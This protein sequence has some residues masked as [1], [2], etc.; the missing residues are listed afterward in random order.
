MRAWFRKARDAARPEH[1]PELEH[2]LGGVRH[3]MKC[4]ETED[5]IDAGV[6][7]VDSP[8]VE[9]EK[10]RCRLISDWRQP[11]I[12]LLAQFQRAGGDIKRGRRT[13]EL[14]QTAR[15]PARAR[16]EVEHGQAGSKT[17]PRHQLR[18]RTE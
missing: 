13:A 8:A 10:L 9:E 3:V 4:V 11:R 5:A 6:G 7:K 15:G 16:A 12:E 2:R 17:Q 14:C 1:P 18:K